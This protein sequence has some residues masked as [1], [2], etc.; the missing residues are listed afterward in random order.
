MLFIWVW[1]STSVNLTKKYS[2]LA[3]QNNSSDGYFWFGCTFKNLDESCKYFEEA[4]NRNHPAGHF[5]YGKCLL[6]G[7]GIDKDKQ[8]AILLMKKSGMSCES[9]FDNII[10]FCFQNGWYGFPQSNAES[11]FF[12]N[13]ASSNQISDC[14]FFLLKGKYLV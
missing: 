4:S 3:Y 13:I 8:R 2:Q 7:A 1:R 14:S 6:Y 12:A 5:W 9:Y 10:S 11:T